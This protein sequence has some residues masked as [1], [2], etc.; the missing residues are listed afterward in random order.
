MTKEAHLLVLSE[1]KV[2]NQDHAVSK[3]PLF[4]PYLSHWEMRLFAGR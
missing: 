4:L 3:S 1:G 2:K